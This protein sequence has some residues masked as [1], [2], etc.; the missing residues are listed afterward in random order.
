MKRFHV[1]IA[2]LSFA[3]LAGT[4]GCPEPTD[5]ENQMNG[6]SGGS[7]A[8]SGGSKAGSGGGG[9]SGGSSGSGSGG[10]S[11]GSSAGSG[12]GGS[13]GGSGGG[14]ASGGSGGGGGQA[15]AKG[16]SGGGGA[17]GGSGGS[18]AGSGGNAGG[19]GG[20]AAGSGGNAGGNGGSS[21]GAVAFATDIQP[22]LKTSCGSC[23]D[24]LSTVDGAYTFVTGKAQKGKCA[25]DMLDRIKAGSPAE[26]LIIQKVEGTQP[27]GDKMPDG[28]PNGS[29]PCLTTDQIQKLKDWVTA[30]AKKN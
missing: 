7:K 15:G 6:G 5:K 14:G 24:G 26:S 29:H 13:S 22:L 4:V 10:S 23:H 25:E 3:L 17:S 2:F 16:G 1:G 8:G 19:S 9:S 12:G 18:A 20:N 27:C 28:C 21:G 11:G 30:G